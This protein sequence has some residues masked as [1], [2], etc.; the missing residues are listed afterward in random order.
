MKLVSQKALYRQPPCNYM[1]NESE[2]K[3]DE[4]G[5]LVKTNVE[6]IKIKY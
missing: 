3:N 2:D 6:T 5:S 1:E 4:E